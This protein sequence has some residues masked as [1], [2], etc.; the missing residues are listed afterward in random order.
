VEYFKYLGNLKTTDARY[1]REIKSS[2]AMT[3]VSF[4][5]NTFLSPEKWTYIYAE[6]I[7]KC[8]ILGM[9]WYDA[10]TWTVRKVDQQISLSVFL[11][12]T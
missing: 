8:Y 11:R 4:K 12:S 2:S 5:D 7:L 6:K 3:K 1:T 10:E 9:A